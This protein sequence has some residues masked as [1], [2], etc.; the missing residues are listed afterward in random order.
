MTSTFA[1]LAAAGVLSL[2]TAA[3][4]LAGSVTQ[5]DKAAVPAKSDVM[6]SVLMD[7]SCLR[8]HPLALF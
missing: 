4:A 3:S 7:A 2:C 6:M 1:K 8:A 5:P